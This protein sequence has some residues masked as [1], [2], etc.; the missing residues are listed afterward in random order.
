MNNPLAEQL[1]SKVMEWSPA[2]FNSVGLDLQAMA[3]YKYDEYQQFSPGMRFTES[4]ASWLGQFP[5]EKRGLALDF[6]RKKLIFVSTAE[7]NHLVSIAYP[8]HIRPLL[9]DLTAAQSGTPRSRIR[10]LASS[11]DFEKLQR[12][13]LF[14]GLS[15]GARTDVFRRANG[16]LSNEQVRQ[17]HELSHDRVKGLLG[18]LQKATHLAGEL[19]DAT[20]E[21]FE[22][23]VLLDDFS[24]SGISY[25]REEADGAVS[26]KIA[27]FLRG[28]DNAADPQ[29]M[30]V[31][32][33]KYQVILL[34]LL[35]TAKAEEHVRKGLKVLADQLG[36]TITV[37]VV[38]RLPSSA[39]LT[40]GQEPA[41]DE[42]LR[43]HYDD[44][45]ETDSTRLGGTDLRY[46]FAGCGL[47]LVLSHNTPNNSIGLI[48]ADGSKMRS[49]FPRVTRHKEG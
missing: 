10:R 13:T 8:D 18:D 49:L 41:F 44:T 38:Q 28:L 34:L 29:S 16:Q 12:K 14:L 26:G 3:S 35:A 22:V 11:T 33:G 27:K 23:I 9:L 19:D 25:V 47:P 31:S 36:I 20:T 7:I 6:L 15:D 46:G 43:D 45:N 48:W 17:S 1:L 21:T 40:E 5:P 42:L 30:L 37:V 39:C 4:L 2:E 24:G 32:K